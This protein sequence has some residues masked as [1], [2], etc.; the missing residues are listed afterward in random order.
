MRGR[1]FRPARRF[2]GRREVDS[3]RV[4]PLRLVVP[5]ESEVGAQKHRIG[6]SCPKKPSPP[7]P[8]F[9]VDPRASLPAA[10]RRDNENGNKVR[11]SCERRENQPLVTPPPAMRRARRPLQVPLGVQTQP[12]CGL[13]PPTSLIR[14][15]AL[16]AGVKCLCCSWILMDCCDSVRKRWTCRDGMN[17]R[18]TPSNSLTPCL[19]PKYWVPTR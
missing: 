4:S 7:V 3:G 16:R 1:S 19:S 6:R 8:P 15:L 12:A 5:L 14:V 9:P 18:K 17:K 2:A 10:P 13:Q 11:N